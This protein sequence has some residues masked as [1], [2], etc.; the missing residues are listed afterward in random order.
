MFNNN[1]RYTPMME[2]NE[3][4]CSPMIEPKDPGIYDLVK[5]TVGILTDVSRMLNVFSDEIT[6]DGRCSGEKLGVNEP[7][8]FR[9]NVYQAHALALGL[10][11]D[12]DSLI[13][14]FR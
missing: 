13:R 11:G 10:R 12:L 9:E 1:D 2:D 3:L 8:C 14:K 4:K 7:S 5:D 6:A